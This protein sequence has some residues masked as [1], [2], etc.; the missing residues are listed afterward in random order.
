MVIL[1]FILVFVVSGTILISE[2]VIIKMLTV[3]S[4][5]VTVLTVRMVEQKFNPTEIAKLP[6]PAALLETATSSS[7]QDYGPGNSNAPETR[8][9]RR[10]PYLED[11]YSTSRT[12]S[13]SPGP[14]H[15]RPEN[16]RDGCVC[17]PRLRPTVNTQHHMAILLQRELQEKVVGLLG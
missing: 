13:A 17:L 12:L 8:N 5:E 15:P 10:L 11:G 6:M 9:K 16:L 3:N 2:Y 14:L 4:K 7:C 1:V